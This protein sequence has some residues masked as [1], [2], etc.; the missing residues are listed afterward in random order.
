M[1][2]AFGEGVLEDWWKWLF[3]FPATVTVVRLVCIIGWFNFDTPLKI[4]EKGY[5]QD[6]DG[7][8]HRSILGEETH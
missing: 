5:M 3:A 2:G 7:A 4:I 6:L 1:I 8:D